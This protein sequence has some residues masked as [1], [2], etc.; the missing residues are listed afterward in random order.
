M[1]L[2]DLKEKKIAIWGLGKEGWSILRVIKQKFHKKPIAILNDNPLSEE[3]ITQLKSYEK[4]SL[5][6]GNNIS[7][8]LLFFDVIIK[9]P[10]VSSYRPEIQIAKNKGVIFTT[11]TNIW[12][13]EHPK[14]IIICITGTKG[15]STTASIVYQL[16][17]KLGFN[18]CLVGN[19]GIPLFDAINM[20]S[21]PDYW[22]VEL[23]SYQLCDFNASPSIGILLNLFSEH[24]DWH[25]DISAYHRDKLNLFTNMEN[26]YAIINKKINKTSL[27][28]QKK[29]KLIYFN[30]QINIHYSNNNI[31]DGSKILISTKSIPFQG[32]H[33]L[34]NLCAAL[35]VIRCLDINIQSCI[36]YLQSLTKLPHRL[37][38]VGE[39]DNKIYV[40]DSISTIPES[41]IAAVKSFKGRP[42]TILLGGFDRGV[43][44]DELI[45]FLL[46][47]V[48]INAV[49]TMPSN[50]RIIAELFK[51]KSIKDDISS[52]SKLYEAN[53]LF[54]AVKIA[55][56]VTPVG[57]VVLL[58]PAASS[59]DKFNNFEE[60]GLH[61]SN[62]VREI[63]QT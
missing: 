52:L 26:K 56:R 51:K 41:A 17:V 61:F 20:D 7:S 34:S 58:S 39:W 48:S 45:D 53:N 12:F 62:A 25:G 29:I 11:T 57:G 33:N 54:H 63:S 5:Y 31:Y 27:Q 35:T 13:A 22:I 36:E 24:L 28:F 19:I 15:K 47:N 49:I 23:S 21:I 50:G 55:K 40:D 30:D 2:C 59:Y 44:Y 14:E 46:N 10:G 8:S 43:I 4:I 3:S 1:R 60:R 16:L 18:A 37:S 6:V 9:S 42:I 32:E 38:I